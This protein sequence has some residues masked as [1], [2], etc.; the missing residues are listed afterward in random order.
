MQTEPLWERGVIAFGLDGLIVPASPTSVMKI[1]KLHATAL[2]DGSFK[3]DKDNIRHADSLEVEKEIY[4]RLHGVKSLAS[5]LNIS[6]NG[7]E[8][9]YYRN[10]YL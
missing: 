5:C 1:P 9:E 2:P 4:R 3:S 10:G 7:L 6:K 8:L